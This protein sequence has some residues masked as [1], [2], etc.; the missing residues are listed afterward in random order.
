LGFH[1]AAPLLFSAR[2]QKKFRT[3]GYGDAEFSGRMV[4]C[5]PAWQVF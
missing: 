4:P 1:A 2:G 3:T 5:F